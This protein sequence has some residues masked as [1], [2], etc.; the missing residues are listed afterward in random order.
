MYTN[1]H[2]IQRG[3]IFPGAN[4]NLFSSEIL[5][6]MFCDVY[7]NVYAKQLQL[8]IYKNTFIKIMD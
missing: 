1:R 4:S 2:W 8:I 6:N 5:R 7:V 3:I